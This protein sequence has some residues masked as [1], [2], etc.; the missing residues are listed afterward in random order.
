MRWTKPTRSGSTG[1]GGGG[2][3]EPVGGSIPALAKLTWRSADATG[4]GASH[5]VQ[6][7]SSEATMAALPSTPHRGSPAV[8]R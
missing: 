6:I 4:L 8:Q 7:P 3:P 2:S 5:S 1:G